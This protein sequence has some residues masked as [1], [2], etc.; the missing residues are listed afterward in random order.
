MKQKL[1]KPKRILDIL[2]KEPENV[3]EAIL[4]YILAGG[5]FKE[6]D[7]I[8]VTGFGKN[9][10]TGKD[11]KELKTARLLALSKKGIP[12]DLAHENIETFGLEGMDLANHGY[13]DEQIKEMLEWE[14]EQNIKENQQI[15]EIN[16]NSIKDLN[17]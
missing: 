4:Q 7:F 9:K 3:Q 16:I 14:N 17:E 15:D 2:N 11:S 10:G 1:A 5:R 8:D 13:T 12:F 6:Q